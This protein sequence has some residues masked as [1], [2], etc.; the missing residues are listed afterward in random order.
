MPNSK[1]TVLV[2][3]SLIIQSL[4]IRAPVIRS[5]SQQTLGTSIKSGIEA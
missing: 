5:L 1:A 3:Q 4:G 2:L